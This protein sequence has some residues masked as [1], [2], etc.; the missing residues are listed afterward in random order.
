[1]LRLMETCCKSS[2]K[3][4]IWVCVHS[5]EMPDVLLCFKWVVMWAISTTLYRDFSF[6]TRKL[7][8]LACIKGWRHCNPSWRYGSPS[9]TSWEG[10]V[11]FADFTEYKA[12]KASGGSCKT[13][14]LAQWRWPIM[15]LHIFHFYKCRVSNL[16]I[17]VDNNSNVRQM[18]EISSVQTVFCVQDIVFIPYV[19]FKS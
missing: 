1:M 14:H 3:T 18:C 15:T 2:H 19:V 7:L 5:C 6:W 11:T 9:L 8:F 13:R 12:E 4:G 10:P 17:P 16:K